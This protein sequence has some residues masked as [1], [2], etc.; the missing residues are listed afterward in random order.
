[1]ADVLN[2]NPRVVVLT[3]DPAVATRVRNKKAWP[4]NVVDA[5]TSGNA[6]LGAKP[7]LVVEGDVGELDLNMKPINVYI[8]TTDP[9]PSNWIPGAEVVKV[10]AVAGAF[11]V[12]L[13]AGWT[14]AQ[15][16]GA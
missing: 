14:G 8:S 10:Y 7:M 13:L 4:V 6:L 9:L 15:D 3:E 5:P 16:C 1:M 2:A 12:R 11:S